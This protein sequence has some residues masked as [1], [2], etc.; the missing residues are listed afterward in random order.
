MFS[1]VKNIHFVG[2]GGIGM[3]AIAEILI[4]QGFTVS[5]SDLT[6]SEN[7]DYLET[8][9]AKVFFGHDESNIAEAEVVVYSSAVKPDDNPETRAAVKRNIPLIR[10]AEMLAEVSRLNY[11]LGLSGTHGKTTATSICGLIM[12]KAGLDPTVIVGGR[13]RGL[14]GTNA[15]LGNGDW[16]VVEADEFDR[17]FLKL[18]PSIAVINNVEEEHL[19]VYK[20]YEDLLETF[21]EFANKVPFYGFV[22]VGL[23]DAG[24]KDILKGIKKKV[25]SFGIS[26]HS[27][28]RADD[29]VYNENASEFTLI[30][31]DKVLGKI[32][33]NIPGLHNIKNALAAIAVTRELG[34]EFDV[35]KEAIGEFTGVY[36][37]FEFKGEHE[38]AMIV[39]DYA[40]HPTEIRATLE[41]C[42]KGWKKRVVAVFQPHTYTRT[43]NFHT[44]FGRSFDDADVLIVTDVYPAREEPIEGVDGK[45]VAEAAIASGHKNVIYVPKFDSL[46]AEI[47]KVLESNDMVITIGAGDIWKIADK[48]TAK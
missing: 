16:T 45:L 23:D 43:Q 10:R 27:D 5:G 19:D 8:K 36:R 29:I 17:S 44:E 1:T 6:Q 12:I 21:T 3:S 15:R 22:A 42:R 37:R 13:L 25:V 34:V 41:A 46:Y 47:K 26:R 32:T 33:V 40:H 48:L 20:D 7:T 31:R 38:G 30:E 14:G 35:I 9:G 39:D 18:S 24:V 28:Y 11:C 2:I 4:N